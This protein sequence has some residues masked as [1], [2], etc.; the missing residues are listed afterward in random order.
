[1]SK[2]SIRKGR[3][4]CDY[5]IDIDDFDLLDRYT[6]IWK[7]NKSFPC[8]KLRL[9]ERQG[10]VGR[11]IK[12]QQVEAGRLLLGSK[13]AKDIMVYLDGNAT[14][15]C[16]DNLKLFA[17]GTPEYD[18]LQRLLKEHGFTKR[19]FDKNPYPG[20]HWHMWTNKW[21]AYYHPYQMFRNL[22][23]TPEAAKAEIDWYTMWL[24]SNEEWY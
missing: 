22:H 23:P 7:S 10:F 24:N 6:F 16:R 1:M 8:V 19:S 13:N 12:A 21:A 2:F 20:V 18:N 11:D 15:L 3:L 9:E 4:Q 14:N 5:D 17:V